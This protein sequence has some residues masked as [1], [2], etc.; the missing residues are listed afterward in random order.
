MKTYKCS[1][2]ASPC[3]PRKALKFRISSPEQS[4]RLQNVL[5]SLS[6]EWYCGGPIQFTDAPYLYLNL[7]SGITYGHSEVSF[8]EE[9][10]FKEKDTEKFIAKHSGEEKK[11]KKSI[12]QSVE[13]GL[14]E[15][16]YKHYLVWCESVK[17]VFTAYIDSADKRWKCAYSHEYLTFVV[18]SWREI[19]KG[20]S[21]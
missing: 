11:P 21:V 8:V 4:E 10:N 9:V 13:E 2:E 16:A 5:Y 12:W 14:P 6:C 20:P 18:S 3:S 15:K 17:C 19:P 7:D 1:A